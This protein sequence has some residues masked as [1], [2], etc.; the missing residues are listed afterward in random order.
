ML[1]LPCTR[2]RIT[3][4]LSA[5]VPIIFTIFHDVIISVDVP[6]YSAPVYYLLPVRT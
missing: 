5:L 2:Y 3:I 6:T 4:F 1:R